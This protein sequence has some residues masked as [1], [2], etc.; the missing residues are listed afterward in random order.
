MKYI[1]FLSIFMVGCAGAQ[2]NSKELPEGTS[3]RVITTTK[4]FKSDTL[5]YQH[6]DSVQFNGIKK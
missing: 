2:Y 4:V 3:I 5:K 1:L 6:T